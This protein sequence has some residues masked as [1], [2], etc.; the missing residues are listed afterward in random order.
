VVTRR[1]RLTLGL[2]L[3]G[4]VVASV[5][6]MGG[7]AVAAGDAYLLWLDT[8]SWERA[9]L[10]LAVYGA[11]FAIMVRRSLLN[12]AAVDAVDTGDVVTH[13]LHGQVRVCGVRR[14]RF[15]WQRQLVLTEWPEPQRVPGSAGI[16]V[17]EYR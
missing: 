9:I 12:A 13:P 4:L 6:A 16:V 14:G 17:T 1:S 8:P 10:V 5:M 2:L 7:C 15:C 3:V 11:T